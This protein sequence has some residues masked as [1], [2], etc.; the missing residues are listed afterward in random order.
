ML[1]FFKSILENHNPTKMAYA[2]LHKQFLMES[3]VLVDIS[4]QA[5]GVTF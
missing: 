4:L 2:G 1:L 3:R 5:L